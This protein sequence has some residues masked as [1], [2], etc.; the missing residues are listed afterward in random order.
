MKRGIL[1]SA[2]VITIITLVSKSIGFVKQA[3]IAGYFGSSK[4]TDIFFLASGLVAN[5]LFAIDTALITV[6]LPLYREKIEKYDKNVISKFIS[7]I[8][9]FFVPVSIAIIAIFI[10]L[11][12]F[13]ANIVAST[14]DTDFLVI[15]TKYLRMISVS[16][17]FALIATIFS[18]MLNAQRE[19]ILPRIASTMISVVPIF[20]IVTLNEKIGIMALVLSVPSAYL[21]QSLLMVAFMKMKSPFILS[22]EKPNGE[23]KKILYLIMPVLLGNSTLQINQLVDRIIAT[24]L[25]EG[26]VSA[27]AY[28]GTLQDFVSVALTA[29]IVTVIFTELSSTAAKLDLAQHRHYL[30]RGI[31]MLCI[32]IVPVSVITIMYSKDIVSLVYQRGVFNE[33]AVLQTAFVLSFYAIGFLFYG[34]REIAAKS[35]YSFGNTKIPTINGIIAVITNVILSIVLSRYF[36]VGGIALASS[37]AALQSM[38][39]LLLLLRK[40]L[41]GTGLKAL[42]PTILKLILSTL[43][44]VAFLLY[45]DQFVNNVSNITRFTIVTIVGL[46]VYILSL[47]IFKCKELTELINIINQ[48]FLKRRR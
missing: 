15:L 18:A 37:I 10:L 7:R 39:V 26:A 44:M 9:L 17:V 2:G 30:T 47:I 4:E 6:I 20:L 27:L 23:I 48:K 5:L 40:K 22:W 42:L 1:F 34:I 24:S 25:D 31:S 29:S 13:I 46:G 32:I 3:L 41:Q 14:Y 11:A 19:Y 12:P 36:G 33:S 21:M 16:L 45:V 35:F 28:S 38:T 43:I 8:I